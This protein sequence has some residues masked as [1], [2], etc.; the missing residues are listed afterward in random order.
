MHAGAEK[1]LSMIDLSTWI[2]KCYTPTTTGCGSRDCLLLVGASVGSLDNIETTVHTEAPHAFITLFCQ[3]CGH[4]QRFEVRCN[5]RLCP[6]CRARDY[7]RIMA[8]FHE[9]MTSGT[10]RMKSPKLLTLTVISSE[11]LAQ[12]IRDLRSAW[13]HIRRQGWF[14]RAVAGGLYT[15]EITYGEAGWH[16]HIHALMDSVFVPQAQISEAWER[17][18]GAPVVDIRPAWNLGLGLRYIL[19]Y[20]LKPPSLNKGLAERYRAVLKGARLVH[21]FGKYYDFANKLKYKGCRECEECG[22]KEV[23]ILEYCCEDEFVYKLPKPIP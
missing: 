12:Q 19:K 18:T 6:I 4:T 22:S 5:D 7:R 10:L 13:T 17:L 16:A 8:R 1:E 14:K 11:D 3:D 2:N 20:M 15:I 21:G 23:I 9:A